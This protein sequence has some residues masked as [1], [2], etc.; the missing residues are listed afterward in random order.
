MPKIFSKYKNSEQ[1]LSFDKRV[2]RES[3]VI[4]GETGIEPKKENFLQDYQYDHEIVKRPLSRG[5]IRF[6][7]KPEKNQQE[8]PK[9]YLNAVYETDQLYELNDGFHKK[10]LGHHK[11]K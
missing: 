10:V 5:H 4:G 1:A 8:Q 11:N 2:T 7:L 6:E 9:T 3:S